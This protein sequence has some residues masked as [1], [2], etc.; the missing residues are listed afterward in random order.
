MPGAST[1]EL[2]A[3]YPAETSLPLP[4]AKRVKCIQ[5][6]WSDGQAGESLHWPSG[7]EGIARR[8]RARL[9]GKLRAREEVSE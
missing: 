4:A 5:E 7:Q 1:F 9:T 2:E 8:S 6:R 3:G